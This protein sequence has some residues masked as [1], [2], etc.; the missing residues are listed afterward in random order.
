M[1]VIMNALK[2]LDELHPMTK[3][4]IVAYMLIAT[5]GA[6]MLLLS[7]Y[8]VMPTWMLLGNIG[9][10]AVNGITLIAWGIR[11]KKMKAN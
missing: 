2:K 8:S 7:A 6:V 4:S 10:I 9:V 5:Y 3:S 11:L 1:K